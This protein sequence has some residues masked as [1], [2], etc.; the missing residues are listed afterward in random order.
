MPHT[1]CAVTVL[2]QEVAEEHNKLRDRVAELEA[3]LENAEESADKRLRVL[4]QEHEQLRA[5]VGEARN[6]HCL[7]QL[8]ACAIF[9]THCA[10]ALSIPASA[11]CH[12]A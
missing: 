1:I 12:G 7:A 10:I 2:L 3:A 9:L 11:H 5:Q 8:V 4:Q 6:P